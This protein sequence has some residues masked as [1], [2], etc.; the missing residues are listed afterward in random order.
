MRYN[1][2][3]TKHETPNTKVSRRAFLRAGALGAVG[4]PLAPYLALKAAVGRAAAR[5][6]SVLLIYTMGG[7]SHHDSFDPKPDA[8]AEVRGEFRT[9]PTRV[10]SVRFSEYVPRLARMLDQ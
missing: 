2:P 8:P 9:I 4:F 3:N 6:K 5:A 7:I 10:P 1:T